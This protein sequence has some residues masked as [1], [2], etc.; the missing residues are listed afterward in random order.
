M[1]RDGRMGGMAGFV[2]RAGTSKER[3]D[4]RTYARA[5][6]DVSADDHEQPPWPAKPGQHHRREQR[7]WDGRQGCCVH[8]FSGRLQ[9]GPASEAADQQL[10][11][12]AGRSRPRDGWPMTTAG[13]EGC[14]G[15]TGSHSRA[16]LG[17]V[18][19]GELEIDRAVGHGS[20][21]SIRSTSQLCLHL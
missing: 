16:S 11:P 10:Q 19:P 2:Q 6:P 21:C 13:R 17:M 8:G 9:R 3:K 5:S 7:E 4:V 18:D 15:Q 1:G 14:A 12:P 20:R